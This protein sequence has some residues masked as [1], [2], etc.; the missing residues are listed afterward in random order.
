[1]FQRR[2]PAVVSITAIALGAF[3]STLAFA[4]GG[5]PPGAPPAGG[6]MGGPPGGP[7]GP[8]GGMPSPAERAIEYRQA[9]FTVISGNF[10]PLGEVMRGQSK[11]D[12]A[13]ITKAADRTA[14]L[15]GLVGEA[16]P[17]VSKTGHTQA[18][19]EIWTH[20]ADFDKKVTDF[21]NAA[22]ALA[23]AAKQGNADATKKAIGGV[24][25]ACKGCH[26]DYRERH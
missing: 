1:M 15:A 9:L 22:N 3:A 25:D 11:L 7:G 23:V 16:F 21:V 13:A 24:G 8:P 26:E 14:F 6:P 12:A 19:P 20:R 18:K 10:G 2:V 17:D 4:Q 5:P